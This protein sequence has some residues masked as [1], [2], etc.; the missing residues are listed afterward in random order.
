MK[1]R[2]RIPSAAPLATP[3]ATPLRTLLSGALLAIL[4][5]SCLMFWACGDDTA[6]SGSDQPFAV[7]FVVASVPRNLPLDSIEI[8]IALGDTGSPQTFTI[9]AKTGISKATVQA[10]PGQKYTLTFKFFSGGFEIGKGGLSGVLEKDMSIS[11]A[12]DWDQAKVDLAYASVHSGKFL[13]NYLESSFNLAL[14]GKP[15]NLLVDSAAGKT[16][17]WFVR[18]GDSVIAEGTGT[19]ITWIPDDSLAS[20]KIS[21]K[22][23]VLNGSTI[24]EE[25]K[26]DVQIIAARVGDRLQGIVSKNDSASD[27]GSL[28]FFKYTG[29]GYRDSVLIYDT[30]LF[31]K[32]RSPVASIAYTY[33]TIANKDYV[34]K[35]Y[36]Q[37][38]GGE[39]IDSAFGY[40]PQG[41]LVAVTVTM[42]SGTSVDS[43]AYGS[44]GSVTTRSYGGGK[45]TRILK[46]NK[47]AG[48]EEVDSSF[49]R[50]DT[51]LVVSRVVRSVWRDDQI[52]STRTY[53][54]KGGLALNVSERFVYNGLG[55]LALH[56][57]YSESGT[58]EL[59]KS[60]TFFYNA[61]GLLSRAVFKDETADEIQ[62][63]QYFE[64]GT[65]VKPAPKLSV[66][67]I[68]NRGWL[69]RLRESS[70]A[71]TASSL[72]G[73]RLQPSLTSPWLKL[74][75]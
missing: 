36:A 71:P 35:A 27:Q 9:D 43:L 3:G 8:H 70:G 30:T 75:P 39:G 46:H 7:K 51:A 56:F 41:R 54:N 18:L 68:E 52:I 42:K 31:I 48:G 21:L 16:Y 55:S 58:S 45:L 62:A 34:Q 44:D 69:L 60:E 29:S 73:L 19:H 26:W 59:V 28:T 1:F 10:F 12:P 23:Q 47:L 50:S 17:R 6:G 24:V 65:A 37:F 53:V 11:L 63:I 25:K 74:L 32:D 14:T 66:A 57:T 22:I 5:L 61:G 38:R 20:R 15:L 72:P 64:Y 67:Q 2:Q 33:A 40:D 13:P 4:A 49:S